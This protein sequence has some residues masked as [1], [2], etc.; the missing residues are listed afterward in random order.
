MDEL[1]KMFDNR[2]LG[3]EMPIIGRIQNKHIKNILVKL[4]K[5]QQISAEKKA[6]LQI[7]N[8]TKSRPGLSGLQIIIDVDPY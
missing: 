1:R 3:P 7:I 2:V 8:T 6:I 4:E 5:G